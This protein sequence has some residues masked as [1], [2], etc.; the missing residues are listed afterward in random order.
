MTSQERNQ[1]PVDDPDDGRSPD[2]L[3][4][5]PP[6]L[7][8]FKH[9]AFA[10]LWSATLV[11]NIGTWMNDVG[12]GW[13]MTTLSP[14]PAAVAF[15]QAA[16]TLPVFLFALP[17]GAL[18]DIVDR[19]K[20]LLVVNSLLGVTAAIMTLLVAGE[21]MTV[22]LLLLFTFLLGSGAAFLAPAWQAIV[23]M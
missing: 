7:A 4:E 21:R 6:P 2:Q 14:S 22:E 5:P 1:D 23:P 15:V 17:A 19:R 16:T 13:L 3:T 10:L 20:L 9:L 11:S 12:A 18:A 8:P